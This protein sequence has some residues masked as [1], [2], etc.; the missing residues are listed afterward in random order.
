VVGLIFGREE[1]LQKV[2]SQLF[3]QKKGKNMTGIIEVLV[4]GAV[5]VLLVL[6]IGGGKL[7]RALW[8]KVRTADARAAKAIINPVEDA[9]LAISDSQKLI[10]NFREKT[11]DAIQSNRR[12]ERRLAGARAEVTKYDHIAE[13]AMRQGNDNDARE[14]LRKK[15]NAQRQVDTLAAEIDQNNAVIER[16]R[17]ELKRVDNRIDDARVDKAI[18]AVRFEGAKVRVGLAESRA[19][20]NGSSP[21]AN[22]D[23]LREA[24]ESEECKA[25][26]TEEIAGSSESLEEKYQPVGDV[27]AEFAKLKAKISTPVAV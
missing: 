8:N 15:L 1:I 22:L 7:P 9:E 17:G 4:V 10:N 19:G 23:N 27:D 25:E 5:I 2:I 14:A 12:L 20:L 13:L 11:R 6:L 3:K 26:A 24:V 21:L 18:L 16:E